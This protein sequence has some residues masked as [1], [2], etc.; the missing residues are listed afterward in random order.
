MK[1][2][3][4]SLALCGFA[5]M[6]FA[7]GTMDNPISVDDLL[8]VTVATGNEVVVKG[9][10]VGVVEGGNWS[11]QASFTAPFNTNSNLI[12]AGSS[13]EKDIEFCI[14]VQLPSGDVR[15]A[16]SPAG[17]PE[18][19]GHE[20][21][22]VGKNQK[23]F[24][25][26]AG[27]KE[28][29]A[30]KWVGDAPE[31]P[32]VPVKQ[33][34]TKENPLSVSAFL[35]YGAN[36]QTVE[37]CWL[38]GVIVG[39][40]AGQSIDGATFSASGSDVSATNLLV[41]ASADVKDAADCVAV[42]LP[43]GDVRKALNLK[44]NP[45]NL[46][47]TVVLHGVREKYFG[48]VGLKSVDECTID[49]TGVE[50]TPTSPVI[51]SGLV[52]PGGN[53]DGWTFEQGT[54]PE[55]EGIEYVWSW[56]ENY[57]IK[58]SAYVSGQGFVAD[59]WAISPVIDLA[60]CTD[61][62]LNLEQATNFFKGTQQ[63]QAV[64]YIRVENGEWTPVALSPDMTEDSWNFVACTCDLNS[65]KDKK[66]QIGFNYKADGSVCGTWEIKN[67]TIT[68]EG[69][70]TPEPVDPDPVTPAIYAGLTLPGGNA[71]DWTLQDG[72]LPEGLNYVWAWTDNYG[73]KATSYY[74][75]NRYEVESWAISPVIDLNGYKDCKLELEQAGNYFNGM[76]Q[77]QTSVNVRE[78]G[79]EWSVV[80]FDNESDGASWN[81]VKGTA[82]LGFNGK[83]IQVGL[84]YT[85]TTEI[86]GTWEVKNLKV[87]GTTESAVEKVLLG[88]EISVLNG[89][90]IA[91]AGARVFNLNG[92]ETGTRNLAAGIYIVVVNN[93]A[94]K[95][96]V[97]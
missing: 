6:A 72:T 35:D 27:V 83:K 87:T 45:G 88:S 25:I 14:P 95:V 50:P 57:G 82:D 78:E 31:T 10:I 66:V 13:T 90:I 17:H 21:I 7:Q 91:P 49:G 56:T 47:K 74:D 4:L 5:G 86:A 53:A 58:A 38:T 65:Y 33:R 59:A 39:Y 68:G 1:K 85:A 62:K 64:T 16:L 94:L 73:L 42:Q 23:Y 79:G 34:G 93:K 32:T 71:D 97:K 48:V 96:M 11:E 30:Y 84:K 55:T 81:F 24:G 9:Y 26:E 40:V 12:L 70:K 92:A 76:I 37:D 8:D 28:V 61:I 77:E 2:T 51:Y 63:T 46:G 41:A 20:V 67:F 89:N 15:T 54:L 3:L 43:A 44:D 22:L 29:S 52:V 75:G 69:G 60:G 36:G 80:R 19:L 18:N